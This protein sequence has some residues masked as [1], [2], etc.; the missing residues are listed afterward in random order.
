MTAGTET[1]KYFLFPHMTLS[2]D[3]LRT[4][5]IFLPRLNVLEIAR[6][7]SIPQWAQERLSAWPVLRGD[8]L[9]ARIDS[10]LQGYRNFAQVHGGPGVSWV[11]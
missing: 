7:A 11:F 8:D 10:C 9:A 2:D 1:L 4:L 5:C 6:R 3:D